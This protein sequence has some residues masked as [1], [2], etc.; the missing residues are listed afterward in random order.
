[1]RKITLLI[2][3]IVIALNSISA[4]GCREEGSHYLLDDFGDCTDQLWRTLCHNDGTYKLSSGLSDIAGLHIM[5]NNFNYDVIFSIQDV[6]TYQYGA[7]NGDEDYVS[8]NKVWANTDCYI[9]K[10][11]SGNSTIKIKFEDG[12]IKQYNAK[13]IN[14]TITGTGARKH[15]LV[16]N[17]YSDIAEKGRFMVSISDNNISYIFKNLNI[18]SNN[19]AFLR[20]HGNWSVSSSEVEA[21]KQGDLIKLWSGKHECSVDSFGFTVTEDKKENVFYMSP[22]NS[23]DG[24]YYSYSFNSDYTVFSLKDISTGSCITLKKL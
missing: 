22:G 11:G 18:S 16:K 21:Y 8:P 4:N 17:L 24:P 3:V 15:L 12:S 13:L 14:D 5:I 2:L 20:M 1:M 23:Y 6:T 10:Y 19:V 7:E 9:S